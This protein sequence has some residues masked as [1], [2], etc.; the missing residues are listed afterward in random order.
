MA[1]SAPPRTRRGRR[2]LALLL[3]AAVTLAGVVLAVLSAGEF[4]R[5][6]RTALLS[7][8]Q[9]AHAPAWTRPCWPTAR[10]TDKAECQHVRG[11]VVWIQK[12]DPDGDGDRHLLVVDRLHPRIV[13]LSRALGVDRLPRIG[14][15]VDAVGWAMYG[16]SGRPEINTQRL[17]WRGTTKT[18]QTGAVISLMPGPGIG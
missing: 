4:Q 13:K 11:R 5:Y 1:V 12:R 14:D 2:I 10:Y 6:P 9:R 18:A 3:I 8:P 17:L 15:R 16:G 7:A